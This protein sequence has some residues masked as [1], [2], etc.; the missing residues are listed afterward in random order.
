MLLRIE[1]KKKWTELIII[2]KEI[3]FEL[4]NERLEEIPEFTNEANFDDL[5]YNYKSMSWKRLNDFDDAIKLLK[6]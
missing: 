5:I 6:K 1:K 4:F 3:R 2:T